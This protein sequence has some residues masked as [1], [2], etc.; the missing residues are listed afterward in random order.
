MPVLV[1]FGCEMQE[2]KSNQEEMRKELK[3]LQ[4]SRT[5]WGFVYS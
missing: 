2:F 1:Q 4:D 3:K 5:L